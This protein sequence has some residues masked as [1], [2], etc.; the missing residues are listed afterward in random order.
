M[1]DRV[2]VTE[3]PFGMSTEKSVGA[4]I[5]L[6]S[7][8]LTCQ[9]QFLHPDSAIVIS[10]GFRGAKGGANAPPLW[11][12]VVYFCVHNCTNP[13]NDYAAVAWS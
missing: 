12:L 6:T 13:S 10:G 1:K 2:V 7:S 5:V 9:H 11:R 3:N 8:C 4:S